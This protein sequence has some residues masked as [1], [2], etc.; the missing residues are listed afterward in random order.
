METIVERVLKARV[1]S[2]GEEIAVRVLIGRPHWTIENTEAA[3][4][5]TIEGLYGDLVP[6][7]GIDPLDALRNAIGM[8]DGLLAKGRDKYEFYWS[9]GDEY[10]SPA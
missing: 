4:P 5:L 1:R 9:D 3:C 6:I 7:R 10:E 2:S 8:I